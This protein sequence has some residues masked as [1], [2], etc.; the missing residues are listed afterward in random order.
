MVTW[1]PLL[2][3]RV[4]KSLTHGSWPLLMQLYRICHLGMESCC[5]LDAL[6]SLIDISITGCPV[7]ALLGLK[8]GIG[9]AQLQ[10]VV[11]SKNKLQVDAIAISTYAQI[12]P[13]FW[14]WTCI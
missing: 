3:C 7:D 8:I 13:I 4:V 12:G 9:C 11:L 14:P 6:H 1:G 5:Y 2:G 10:S